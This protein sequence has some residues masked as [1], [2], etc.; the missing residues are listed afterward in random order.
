MKEGLVVLLLLIASVVGF[1]AV[2]NPD[3][4]AYYSR[5]ANAQKETRKFFD[6]DKSFQKAIQFNPSDDTLRIEYGNFLVDQRKYFS[7]FQQFNKILVES[8]NHPV[9]LQKMT[10]VSFFLNRWKD[11]ISYGSKL[12]S[13]NIGYKVGFM[14]GKAYYEEED[15]GQAEKFLRLAITETPGNTEAIVL[16]GKVYIEL[17]EYKKALVMYTDALKLDENSNKL[18]YELGLL[19]STL[20]DEKQA[21]KYMEL[22]AEKGYKTDLDYHENLGMAYLSFDIDK[23]VEILNRVLAKKPNDEEIMTQI[24]QAHYKSRHFQVAADAFYKIYQSDP[25]NAR[26]LYMTGIA[27]QKKGDKVLGVSL[28]NKAIELDPTLAELKILMYSN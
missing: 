22:A 6:A 16:L 19:Y 18:I 23:G 3:S 7:A 28:C 24:A 11:V 4:A 2:S 15:Y 9:A 13:N 20:N 25:S 14:I 21:V 12:I 26:A 8:E 27:Y 17:S 10:E 5:L 1:S